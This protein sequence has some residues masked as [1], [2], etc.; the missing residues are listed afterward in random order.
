MILGKF[1]YHLIL[2]KKIW[3]S[4]VQN[5]V[6]SFVYLSFNMLKIQICC[7]LTNVVWYLPF[8]Q[9]DAYA[10]H[11]MH[12]LLA[13][14]HG[15]LVD[16]HES[17]AHCQELVAHCDEFLAC[18]HDLQACCPGL[19]AYCHRIEWSASGWER[20]PTYCSKKSTNEYEGSNFDLPSKMLKLE[21][22]LL[23]LFSLWNQLLD[24]FLS[25]SELDIL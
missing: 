4:Q 12:V 23:V 24:S 9:I 6:F 3:S 1:M 25:L 7:W 10:S 17:V 21:L 2:E 18:C 15:W 16:W 14:G 22:W 19:P 5:S 20:M 8:C 11:C 13:Y